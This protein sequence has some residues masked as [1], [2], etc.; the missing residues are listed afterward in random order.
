MWLTYLNRLNIYLCHINGKLMCYCCFCDIYLKNWVLFLRQK[1]QLL[2]SL[3]NY[4]FPAKGSMTVVKM[5]M[6][7]NE[8]MYIHVGIFVKKIKIKYRYKYRYNK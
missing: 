3:N 5:A 7:C 6:R 1:S 8:Y 4:R 2:H